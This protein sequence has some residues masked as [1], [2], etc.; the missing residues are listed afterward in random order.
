MTGHPD[1]LVE[2]DD[3]TGT[4]PHDITEF[5]RLSGAGIAIRGRGRTSELDTIGSTEC[6]LTL[7][8]DDA[9]FTI[10]APTYGVHEDQPLRVTLTKGAT[11]SQRFTGLVDDWPNTWENPTGRTSR[12]EVSAIDRLARLTRTEITGTLYANEILADQPIL[13]WPLTDATGSA[14]AVEASG[15]G[16]GSLARGGPGSAMGFGATAGAAVDGQTSAEFAEGE[17]LRRTKLPG[18]NLADFTVE[19]V[20]A[21]NGDPD[22]YLIRL[23]NTDTSSFESVEFTFPSGGALLAHI[24]DADGTDAAFGSAMGYAD[25]DTHHVAVT[26]T[27]SSA[28]LYLDGTLVQTISTAALTPTT[29]ARMSAFVGQGLIGYMSHIAVYDQALAADRIASHA[30]AALDGAVTETSDERLTRLARYGGLAAADLDLEAGVLEGLAIQTFD[31]TSLVDAMQAVVTSEGGV[32]FIAG[33]GR[34]TFHS[35]RHR[36]VTSTSTPGVAIAVEDTDGAPRVATSRRD[37]LKNYVT[38]SRSGGSQQLARDQASIDAVGQYPDDLGELLVTTDDEVKAAIRWRLV[39]HKTPRQRLASVTVDLLT[40]DDA[41]VEA[42][43]ALELGDRVTVSGFP[44][45]SAFATADMLIEGWDESI[46]DSSWEITFNTVPA[47]LEQAWRLGD[48][49]FSV[50]GETTRLHY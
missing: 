12:V 7:K 45:Q 42:I 40:L 9:R 2:L 1:I 22:G 35:R 27:G 17:Y 19:L 23:V 46:T 33:D 31:S 41:L 24:T 4:F 39:T 32:M 25:G 29:P 3:G 43:L 15:L 47:A 50:L 36:A 10:G 5:V 38:G 30:A 48:P 13:Y 18:W 34:L 11:T 44:T 28:R 6:N 37:Y 49:V 20:F 14:A 8:N 16:R 26:C 21:N